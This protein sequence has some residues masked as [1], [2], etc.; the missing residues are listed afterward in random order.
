MKSKKNVEEAG[1]SVERK[2]NVLLAV[3]MWIAGWFSFYVASI[4]MEDIWLWV[5]SATAILIFAGLLYK[6]LDIKIRAEK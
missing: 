3:G 2:I 6:F 5:I 1:W 4:A